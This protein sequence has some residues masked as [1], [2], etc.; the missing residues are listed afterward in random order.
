MKNSS[1][2]SYNCFICNGA[3]YRCGKN[4]DNCPV[5]QPTSNTDDIIGISSSNFLEKI[6]I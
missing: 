4:N 3:E 2:C 5:P 1:M 6:L